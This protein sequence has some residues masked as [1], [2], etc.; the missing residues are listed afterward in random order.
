ML[1]Y[2]ICRYKAFVRE[3]ALKFIVLF[4]CQLQ[5]V[6]GARNK[7]SAQFVGRSHAECICDCISVKTAWMKAV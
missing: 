4:I 2:L 6:H 7:S 1:C 3:H 5:L